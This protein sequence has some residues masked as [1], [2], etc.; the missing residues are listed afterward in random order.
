M[1]A[2][3]QTLEMPGLITETNSK[4]VTGNKVQW[5]VNPDKFLFYDYEMTV[6][7]RV[8]NRWAFVVSGLFFF[9]VLILMFFKVRRK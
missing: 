7:S 1:D 2:Y 8:V 4:S 9:L 3:S 6:E 5:G